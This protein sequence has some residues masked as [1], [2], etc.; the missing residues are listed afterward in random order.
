MIDA[1]GLTKELA[2][3][4]VDGLRKGNKGYMLFE[5]EPNHMLPIHCEEYV[6]SKLFVYAGQHTVTG[7]LKDA[8]PHICIEDIPDIN[9]RLL[10]KEV[11]TIEKIYINQYILS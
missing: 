10:V 1:K 11:S 5:G 4:I 6:Q 2:Y 3:T 8:I 7:Y 9:T